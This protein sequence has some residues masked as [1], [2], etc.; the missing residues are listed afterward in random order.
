MAG[1][2][3][4][5]AIAETALRAA[6]ADQTEV[7]VVAQDLSLTRFAENSIH[8]NVTEKNAMVRVRSV[9]G[10]RVGV[11]ST[12]DV[13]KDS[14]QDLVRRAETIAALQQEKPT[15]VVLPEPA[16]TVAVDAYSEATAACTPETRARG[17]EAILKLSKSNDL[18]ASGAYSTRVE[19]TL[20]SN[21]KGVSA[22]HR[23]TMG[24]L[25]TVIMSPDSSGYAADAAQDVSNIDAAEV[26][27]IAVDKALQSRT[28]M[29]LEPGAYTVIL[30][31]EAVADMIFYLSFLGLGA[32][33]VQEGRSF[34]AGRIGEKV[35]GENI[36]L[37]DDGFDRRGIAH[38]FDY[39]GVPK[40]K[41]MLIENGIAL[42]PVYDTETA[43]R[44]PGKRSTGHG[45]PAPNTMGPIPINLFLN[46][47]SASI[48]E[49]IA[50]TERGIYVTRFHYVNPVHPVKT[51]ITGMTRDGTFLVENGKISRPLKNL[52][53]TQSILE[54]LSNTEQLSRELKMVT[55]QYGS[56]SCC[57]PAIK[58]HGFTFTG[59]T[60]F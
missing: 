22:Y 36:T 2:A 6:Q 49:M 25:M 32:L 53:F 54:T 4:L 38:P 35:A 59:A 1:R 52:R 39:E 27:R 55:M 41:V 51:I 14:L 45:L 10:S 58:A 42:G 34:M 43:A 18:L 50:S 13:S 47:G 3:E 20:V 21:S 37:W 48:E 16:E 26:G 12:T 17:V 15:A 44:E 11:A 56:F 5:Q 9:L 57:V 33:S 8:Q 23:G 29:A 24:S 19:E 7:L 60:E 31:E 28:P 40:Q 46:T 30:E